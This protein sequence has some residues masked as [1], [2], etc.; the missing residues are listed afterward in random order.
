MKQFYLFNGGKIWIR[1]SNGEAA[2]LFTLPVCPDEWETVSGSEFGCAESLTPP[3]SDAELLPLRA[4]F[5]CVSEETFSQ[6][7]QARQL[8]YWRKT[9]RFCGKCGTR[10]VRDGVE[11]AMRCPACGNLCY[12][13]LNPAVI[14]LV[15]RDD[16]ILLAHKAQNLY[17][18]WGLI[19]GFVEP[20]ESL[21]HAV[22]R[23]I[24]EEVGIR[25]K[26]IRYFASQPWPFPNNLMLGFTA[27]Y[28]SGTVKPDGSE[29][30][31]AAWYTRD[32]LPKIPTR[33]SI[34]RRL[35]D[36]FLLQARQ[37]LPAQKEQEK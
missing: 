14:T 33:V 2:P 28:E 1:K 7:G 35:I 11:H 26:N 36:A 22:R 12:P 24:M 3:A 19:A 10:L 23:E 34:A 31:G 4:L 25:V 21:E 32:K 5:D 30:D 18:F 16:E 27:E 6:A 29:L 8:V 13:R 37:R 20:N 17:P 15:H 9:N